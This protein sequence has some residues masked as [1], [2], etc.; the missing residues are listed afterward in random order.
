MTRFPY[1]MLVTMFSG[2]EGIEVATDEDGM[3][4]LIV[5]AQTLVASS[6]S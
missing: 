3:C 1:S 4:S 2:H 6:N 5:T